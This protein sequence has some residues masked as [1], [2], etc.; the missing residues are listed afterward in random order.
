MLNILSCTSHVIE[1]IRKSNIVCRYKKVSNLESENLYFIRKTNSFYILLV[2]NLY[3]KY[4]FKINKVWCIS[5]RRLLNSIP[6]KHIC[7]LLALIRTAPPS[8]LIR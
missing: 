5:E 7:L 4:I 8:N 1:F 6:K 2:L 3:D